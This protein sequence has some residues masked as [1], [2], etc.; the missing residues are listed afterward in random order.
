MKTKILFATMLAVIM[1]SCNNTDTPTTESSQENNVISSGLKVKEHTPVAEWIRSGNEAIVKY[2]F[3]DYPSGQCNST[4]SR[5]NTDPNTIMLN[6]KIGIRIQDSCRIESTE[7]GNICY[8]TRR[9]G[10]V[11]NDGD[12]DIKFM[13]QSQQRSGGDTLSC[14]FN[15]TDVD[16]IYIYKPLSTSCNPIPMCYY[17]FMDI[18][19]NPDTH[20]PTQMMII[21]EWN[22]L[23]M[24]GISIDT[25]I[26]HHMEVDDN[27]LS[28]L[29]DNLFLGM[30]D[31]A[32]VNIWL[33][34]EN[35]V[36]IYM[37]DDIV[38]WNDVLKKAEEDTTE[39][40]KLLQNNPEYLYTLQSTSIV[41]G[42]IAHLPIYL[43]RQTKDEI[44]ERKLEDIHFP[45]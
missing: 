22:G 9:Y 2:S 12:N 10:V 35:I 41:Y 42:A 14:I 30:P 31:E 34:R 26:I 19:W 7:G 36:T 44:P 15:T 3:V 4:I 21:T 28:T 11:C 16:P 38:P 24:N 45:K 29:D 13:S 17:H 25:T 23:Q 27:G 39:L 20:N 37:D 32:L 8:L 6:D 5:Y 18:E 43:I 1:I 33:V 40:T